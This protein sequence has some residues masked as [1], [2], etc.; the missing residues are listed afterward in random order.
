MRFIKKINFFFDRISHDIRLTNIK[1]S[2]I[3]SSIT[4]ILGIFSWIVGGRTDKVMLLYIFPRGALSIGIMYFFWALSFITIGIIIGGAASGCEKYKRREAFKTVT[5]LFLSFLCSL[6]VYP[7]FFKSLSPLIAFF[8]LLVSSFFTFLALISSYRI[9]SLW[10]IC[11]VIHL[12]W[13]LY[14]SY[15]SIIIALIN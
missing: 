14:N 1:F 8:V 11:I 12:L 6:C 4:L 9:Y 2:L 5:F 15:I 3:I 13:L 10:T 7:L